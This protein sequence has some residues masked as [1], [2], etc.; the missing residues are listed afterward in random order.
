MTAVKL[1]IIEPSNQNQLHLTAVK[2]SPS[3]KYSQLSLITMQ[4]SDSCQTS[5]HRTFQSESI[6]FDSCQK[7]PSTKSSQLSLITMQPSD[8]CQRKNLPIRKS[9]IH[10]GNP[11]NGHKV[12][13]IQRLINSHSTAKVHLSPLEH[14][15]VLKIIYKEPQTNLYFPIPHSPPTPPITYTPNKLLIMVDWPLS[16]ALNLPNPKKTSTLNYLYSSL[17]TSESWKYAKTQLNIYIK[18]HIKLQVINHSLSLNHL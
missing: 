8:S 5:H 3:T 13:P 7:S 18:N 16:F 11:I 14:S 1:L 15:F 2:K 9:D 4:P 12:K 17:H 6:T 10:K